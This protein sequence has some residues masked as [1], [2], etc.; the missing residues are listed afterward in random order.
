MLRER[1]TDPALYAG[2]ARAA[3]AGHEVTPLVGYGAIETLQG[4][5]FD[6]VLIHPFPSVAVARAW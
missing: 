6:G 3:R 5:P 4:A 1:V 2:S